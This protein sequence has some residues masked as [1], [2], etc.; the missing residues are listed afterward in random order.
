MEYDHFDTQVTEAVDQ[1]QGC[2]ILPNEIEQ[3]YKLWRLSDLSHHLQLVMSIFDKFK[4]EARSS[5]S[6]SNS[7]QTSATR[8][9]I[10]AFVK[11]IASARKL[12]SK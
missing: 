11:V 7:D 3:E 10:P 12:A 1:F 4:I 8:H 2:F 9:N 5:N 6:G